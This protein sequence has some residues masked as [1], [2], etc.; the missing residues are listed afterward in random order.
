MQTPELQ[1]LTLADHSPHLTAATVALGVLR[2]RVCSRPV[3]GDPE[4]SA[5][6]RPGEAAVLGGALSSGDPDQVWDSGLGMV[7]VLVRPASS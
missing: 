1:G 2:S 6:S 5:L 3:P 4:S 7:G